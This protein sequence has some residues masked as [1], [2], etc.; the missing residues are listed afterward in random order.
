MSSQAFW[1][2]N[3]VA[4]LLYMTYGACQFGTYHELRRLHRTSV[5]RSGR[6]RP[7]LGPLWLTSCERARPLRHRPR[8]RQPWLSSV[9]AFG[10]GALAGLIATVATYPFDLL[11]TRFASQTAHTVR[12]AAS[13]R[14][15]VTERARGLVSSHQRA[16]PAYLALAARL[17]PTTFP[18]ARVDC[19]RARAFQPIVGTVRRIYVAEGLRGFYHGLGP[20]VLQILP[21]TGLMYVSYESVTALLRRGH[22]V[23]RAVPV[24]AHGVS[25][26]HR[27]APNKPGVRACRPGSRHSLC[28]DKGKIATFRRTWRP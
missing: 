9:L 18:S 23:G 16:R 28:H 8:A 4:L 6:S 19:L 5:R 13:E 11:R 3:G 26:R 2:G 22:S 20:T 25:R 27:C 7:P 14:E 24:T 1:K 12:M 10:S 21:Y 17:P 15:A